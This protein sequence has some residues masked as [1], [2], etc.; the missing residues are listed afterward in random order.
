MKLASLL[1][2]EDV[3]LQGDTP[4]LAIPKFWFWLVDDMDRFNAF[5]WGY[6]P[7]QYLLKQIRNKDLKV[8]GDTV[9]GRNSKST[10]TYFG[11]VIPITVR[12][13]H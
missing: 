8:K 4:R 5:P 1:F 12:L 2:M 6:V 11:F 3:L 7:F 13:K 10:F 9:F